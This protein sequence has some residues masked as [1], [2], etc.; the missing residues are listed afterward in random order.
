MF[1]GLISKT[2]NKNQNKRN[3]FQNLIIFNLK[4]VSKNK[5]AD[6]KIPAAVLL[7]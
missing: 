3:D 2:N 4:I 5:T 6:N 7:F 1:K